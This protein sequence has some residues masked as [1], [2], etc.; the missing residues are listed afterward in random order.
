MA[1]LKQRLEML[2]NTGQPGEGAACRVVEYESAE[3]LDRIVGA[4]QVRGFPRCVIALPVN[5]RSAGAA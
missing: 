3:H 4:A 2:E 5:H 1:T